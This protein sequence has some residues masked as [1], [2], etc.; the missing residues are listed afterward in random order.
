MVAAVTDMMAYVT[1]RI[2]LPPNWY[3]RVRSKAS[4]GATSCI[5]DLGSR[6]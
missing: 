5:A 3:P 4:C 6:V 2:R 1:C